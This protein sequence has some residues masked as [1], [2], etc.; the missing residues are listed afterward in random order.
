[1]NDVEIRISYNEDSDQFEAYKH[2]G[3]GCDL[4]YWDDDAEE[5]AKMIADDIEELKI[6]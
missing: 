4:I 3:H 5:L 1:M 6:K 2:S